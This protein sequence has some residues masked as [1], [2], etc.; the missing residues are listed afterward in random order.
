MAW[1]CLATSY[2][3]SQ[4]WL[5]YQGYPAKRALP[6]M[7]KHGRSYAWQVGPFWQ[8]T[9]DIC[10][11]M[12]P[13]GHSEWIIYN[14]TTAKQNKTRCTDRLCYPSLIFIQ[15]W[16]ILSRNVVLIPF[17]LSFFTVAN[18]KTVLELLVPAIVIVLW[19]NSSIR[20][21]FVLI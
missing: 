19:F 17:V 15:P 7:R 12:V 14:I 4:C 16:Y 9:L 8:D 2:Y 6:A 10:F 3:L 21:G 18:S 11:H 5:I 20:L 1:C 13:L